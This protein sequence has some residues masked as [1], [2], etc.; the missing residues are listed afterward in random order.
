MPTRLIKKLVLDF[1][2]PVLVVLT[3]L[4]AMS[5]W[6]LPKLKT[7]PSPRLLAPDHESRVAAERLREEYTGAN[8]GIIVMLSV[9]GTENSTVFNPNTLKRVA[10]LT[11]AFEAITLITQADREALASTAAGAP[12]PIRSQAMDL[13]GQPVD[14][15]TWLRVDELSEALSF[16]DPPLPGLEALVNQWP[17]KLSP[18]KKVSSLASTDNILARNG[19]LEVDPIYESVPEDPRELDRIQT[20]V[21]G[22]ELFKKLLVSNGSQNTSINLELDLDVSQTDERYLVYAQVK[23]LVESEF[24]GPETHYIAGFPSVTAA[25]GKAMEEDS[26]IL[27]VAVTLIVLSCLFINF[28][29]IKGVTMPLAVVILSLT[30]TLGT[31]SALAIPLNIITISLPV[32]ILSIGVADGIHMFSEYRD[33]LRAGQDKK[34]AISKTMDHLTLPVIM[35]SLT[36]AAAFYA[37][38]ITRIVQLKYCGLF[39]CLGALVAM[40]FSLLFIPALL[41]ILPE[42][43]WTAGRA[44]G[45]R[46]A[47]FITPLLTG[48]TRQV[49]RKP[50]LAAGMG[51]LVMAVFLAGAMR[52]KV[53]NNSVAFFKPQSPIYISS[54]AMNRDGAGSARLNFLISAPGNEPF[55]LPANLASVNAF[56]D[57]LEAQPQVGKVTA[58]TGL[59]RRIHYVLNDQDPDQ[60]RL[61]ADPGRDPKDT[62]LIAQELLLYENGGGDALSDYVDQ[63]YTKVNLSAVLTTNS[64]RET[65]LLTDKARAWAAAGLPGHLR[66]EVTGTASVEAATT[67]E[68]VTGQI[69]GLT[70]SVLV[71]LAM[72][73]LTFR[74]IPYTLIAMVPL[75][76][77]IVINF[78]VMGFF[79]IPL[80]IG[81]A[82]ISSVVIG[83]GVDYSIHYL[84]R[85]KA[86]LASGMAFT[87][88]LDNTVAHSGKAILSNAVTVGSG[89]LAL[90]FASLTPLIIMGWLITLTMVVSALAALVLL[91]VLASFICRT[92]P[93]RPDTESLPVSPPKQMNT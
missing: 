86:N 64:S 31:M 3:L 6:Y 70:V 84:S 49:I 39:V 81:T 19:R 78:G 30:V 26:K 46:K 35:T 21:T 45:R 17:E 41:A 77:T 15:E 32:F 58:I 37:I 10:D 16:A 34:A 28:R 76:G 72:L 8:D 88:A 43:K 55:K 52:V 13:A 89:F 38:S 12:E 7:D 14:G 56:A 63:G 87:E 27:F 36:T 61:P 54:A 40:V 9:E 51:T 25:L 62:S 69:T 48:I 4:T 47:S 2:I 11:R 79:N 66:L 22:N 44:R 93:A 18:V 60:D 1:P 91:P 68:I 75:V 24:P 83:I 5:A 50:A 33:H 59:I 20:E 73:C 90:W 67:R 85:L 82:I 42:T 74:S 29:G 65:K 92:S 57:F 23:T 71:V 53:D 80:D